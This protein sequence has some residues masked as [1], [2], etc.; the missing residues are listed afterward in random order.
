LTY[1]AVA[2]YTYA[3]TIYTGKF[4]GVYEPFSVI[5][6]VIASVEVPG[7]NVP[8]LDGNVDTAVLKLKFAVLAGT[9]IDP[10]VTPEPAGPGVPVAPVEVALP[11]APVNPVNPVN[12][13]GPVFTVPP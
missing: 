9:L 6:N 7:L 3:V 4:V 2:L 5:V 13:V 11:F 12:P 10:S 1:P 8:K